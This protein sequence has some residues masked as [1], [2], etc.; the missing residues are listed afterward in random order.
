MITSF[1]ETKSEEQLHNERL[2][3]WRALPIQDRLIHVHIPKTGG[4]WLNHAFYEFGI[5]V[6]DH[7]TV[8]YCGDQAS[9]EP[10]WRMVNQ[11]DIEPL[12]Q[13]NN[14]RR[15]DVWETAC[16]VAVVRNPFDWLVSYYTHRGT[17]KWREHQGWDDIVYCHNITSFEMLVKRF[18]DPSCKWFH[19][20]Y[21]RSLFHQIFDPAG[22]IGVD[23]VLRQEKL[24]EGTKE[25]FMKLNITDN[26]WSPPRKRMNASLTRKLDYKSYYNPALRQIAEEHFR[27]ELELFDYSFDGMEDDWAL[28]D[29]RKH[30][31]K[32]FSWDL[33]RAHTDWTG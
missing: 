22:A 31:Q 24:G 6:Y 27:Q 15:P 14:I 5:H 8:E 2:D 28:L 25:L 12:L 4:T 33:A 16:K 7:G 29:V 13:C 10:M 3:T 21:K 32:K 11:M 30:P 26:S 23:Y 9:H 17:G 19:Q 18:C 1:G 20:W